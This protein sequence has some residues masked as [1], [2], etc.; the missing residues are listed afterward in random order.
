MKTIFN[1][2]ER[3]EL[4]ERI[5]TLNSH[6]MAQWGKMNLYQMMK[7]CTRWNDWVLGNGGHSYRQEFLGKLFGKMVLK[8]MVKDDKPMK[9]N[10]PAGI[11][12]IKEQNGDIQDEKKIWLAQMAAYENFSNPEFI[13]DFFGKM[14]TEDIGIFVYKHMDHHLRQFN[15]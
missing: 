10:A 4:I 2:A 1:K 8:G 7:H 15:A 14:K 3:E 11:F 12:T 5:N 6:N 13:H 9:K